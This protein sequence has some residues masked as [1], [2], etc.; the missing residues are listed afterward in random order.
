MPDEGPLGRLVTKVEAR[1]EAGDDISIGLIQELAG[2][3]AAG[4]MLLIPALIV[5]SP[6]SIV[7]GLPTLVGINT[8]LVAGQMAMGH[9]R[10]WLPK[11][12][13]GRSIPA[14]WADKLLTFLRPVSQVTDGVV[15]RRMKFLTSAPVRRVGA[16]VCVL[17]GAIMPFLEF[18]P[19]TS[20]VAASIIAVFALAITARDGLL[21][22]VW[23]GLVGAAIAGAL[24]LLT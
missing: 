10:F 7:P 23:V 8:V 5:I 22:L 1:V 12:L 16:M 17:V 6:L 13:T 19:F 18:I 2:Q 21:A 11:W 14:K 20:T 24:T 15:R 3:R 4:P 9:D